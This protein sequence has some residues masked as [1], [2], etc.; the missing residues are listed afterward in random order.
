MNKCHSI[1]QNILIHIEC[2]KLNI[3]N[4]LIHNRI[5]EILR[6]EKNGARGNEQL[7]DRGFFF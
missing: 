4:L 2:L 3:R 1:S 6:L 5:R 7:A